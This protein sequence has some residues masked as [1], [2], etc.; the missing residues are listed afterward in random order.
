MKLFTPQEVAQYYDQT[1]NHFRIHWELEKTLGL[2]Y[3]IWDENTKTL[4]E[5]IINTNKRLMDLGNILPEH[6]VLDAGCGIGGSSI[7]LARE[8]GCKVT[9]ITISEKQA[10]TA[11]DRAGK[12]GLNT[13]VKFVPC[14]YCNTSF[15][16]HHFDAV[17]CI[18]SMQT[19]SDKA[20]FFKEMF[21][22]LK[23]GGKIFIADFFKS[24]NVDTATD[25]DMRT[26][27][28]GW[29]MSD[30]ITIDQLEHICGDLNVKLQIKDDVTSA[31]KKTVK[32]MYWAG[33][34]GALPSVIYNIFHRA[35]YFSSTHYK[36]CIAQKITYNQH[37]WGYWLI[38]LEKSK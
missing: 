17:W 25:K 18:E 22:V 31:V 11:T 27:L 2:H 3:G 32:R 24:G 6:H 38:L 16:D 23:P 4:S 10:K 1:E 37:K 12:S 13:K 21:R 35:S 19:A 28:Y 30:I 15:P 8:K 7:Y 9:G 26:W 14:D 36:T 33:I 34:G 20:L 29:A 5:A